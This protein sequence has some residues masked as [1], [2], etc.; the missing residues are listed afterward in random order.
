M[1][2]NQNERS[3]EDLLDEP[4][5]TRIDDLREKGQ[6][7]QSREITSLLALLASAV[8]LYA[9]APNIYGYLYEYM[10]DIFHVDK[11]TKI[12]F[13]QNGVLNSTM[14]RALKLILII[15]VP[16]AVAGFFVGVLASFVQVGSIFSFEPIQADA[17]RINPLKGLMKLLSWNHFVDSIRTVFKAFL[18]LIVAYLLVKPHVLNSASLMFADPQQFLA[19]FSTS[20]KSMFMSLFGVFMV[21]AGFDFFLQRREWMKQVRLTRQ[22]A[23]EEAKERDGNPQIKARIRTIQRDM[24]R[25]R[26]MAAVKKADVIVTNP[27]HIA[28]AIK[29]E[30]DKMLAPKVVA[31]GADFM[32]QKIKQLASEAGIPHVENVP[33]A[34]TLYKSVKVNQYIP[35]ALYHAVAEVLAYVFKIKNKKF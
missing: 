1:A 23:K 7:V 20:G 17:E 9:Y 28:I 27:T 31:K 6:V 34:R 2:E 26:M 32:A 16:V 25:K 29:Y 3:T 8:V 19:T 24:A 35:R 14:M 15:T 22:E 18:A 5:Q 12:D 11:A 33:L 21:F 10:R 13:G 30:K 4:S